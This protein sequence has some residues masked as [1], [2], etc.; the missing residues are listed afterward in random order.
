MTPRLLR[1]VRRFSCLGT[2]SRPNHVKHWRSVFTLGIAFGV[3][4]SNLVGQETTGTESNSA[5]KTVGQADEVDEILAGHSY[6]GDVFNEGPRQQA[7]LMGGTG[8]VR[9]PVTTSVPLAQEF[10]AQG[11]GQLYGFWYLEAERSFRHAASLDA[12]CAMAYWGAAMANR[13]NTKRAKGFIEEA[14]KRKDNAGEREVMYINALD[15]YLKTDSKERK[16]RNDAYTKALENLLLEY[17]DDLE[18]KAFLALHLYESKSSSTSYFAANA[19][20]QEIFDVEPM[21]SAHHFRIHFWDRRHPEMA[22]ASAAMCGQASPSIAH[23]WHMPGHIYSRLH[24][25]EDAVWQQ[26]ASA[27]VDHAHMMRDRVMPDEIGNFAHNN[28]WLIRNLIHVGRVHDAVDLAKNMIELPRHPR[29]NTLAKRG[30]A[31]YGRERLF[32]VLRTYELW[33]ELIALAD[34]PYLEPTEDEDEQIKRLRYLGLAYF[35]AGDAENGKAQIAELERRQLIE[36]GRRMEAM[37]EEEGQRN[38]AKTAKSDDS[39]SKDEA[40]KEVAKARDEFW[41]KIKDLESA[42]KALK[43][44]EAVCGNDYRAGYKLLKDADDV[45]PLYLAQVQWHAGDR[46][47]ALKAIRKIVESNENEVRPLAMLVATLWNSD[48]KKE[49]ETAFKEL[50]EL[51]APIDLDVPVFARLAPIAKKSGYEDDW[52]IKSKAADDV[53]ERPDLDSLGP[54]RWSPS[55]APSWVLENADGQRRSAAEF[56]GRPH[57]VIFYLGIGCL[58]CAEQLQA[59]A[60][61]VRAFEQAGLSIVAIST[62]G[63]K[64]LKQS[65][66]D[67]GDEGMPIPLVS[68]ESLDVFRAF[69]VYDD[70]E[71]QPLHGTFLIDGEGMVRWQDVG[72]EPFMDP[73]FVLNEAERLLSQG[74]AAETKTPEDKNARATVDVES[75]RHTSD[76]LETVRQ[77]LAN[78]D[79]VLVDVREQ[80]EWESGHLEAATLVPLSKLKETAGDDRFLEQLSKTLPLDK[81]VYCHCRSGGRVLVAAPILRKLG[82]DVRALKAGYSKLL[83]AGFEPGR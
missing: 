11:V 80:G 35:Q 33:D 60:P 61:K 2:D 48:K 9:F 41:A 29:Y 28:E 18:A 76:S 71:D 15:A 37:T 68:N 52:R 62:D 21:H 79:A 31:N 27:R 57:V 39:E 45:D 1:P 66:D 55:L 38:K 26:E 44:H 56:Q 4:V 81:T 46:E 82:Y 7:Y 49:A 43:G 6:H 25:Y 12:D 64:T 42:I 3:F 74:V 75:Q 63:L 51:S 32:Q 72:Y 50:R 53:G 59:F 13:R 10:F 70:F 20:L 17:P 30:S 22:L 77:A 34:S 73:D 23:M 65:I 16:K 14:V 78:G 47:Q 58:H 40:E 5:D 54:F 83:E 8:R 67:Y 69:R 24:R 36:L 19:L